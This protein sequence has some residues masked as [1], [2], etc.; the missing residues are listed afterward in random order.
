MLHFLNLMWVSR[1]LDYVSS[2]NAKR[3]AYFVLY[4]HILCVI[5]LCYID[6]FFITILTTLSAYPLIIFKLTLGSLQL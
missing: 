6:T 2:Q 4:L 1:F 5:A 3:G